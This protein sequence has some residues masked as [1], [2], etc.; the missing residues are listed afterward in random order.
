MVEEARPQPD[1]FAVTNV[2][3]DQVALFV[4]EKSIDKTV[5][6]ALQKIVAQKTVV[7]DLESKKSDLDDEQSQIFRRPAAAP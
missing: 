5:E 2:T 4:R 1:T 6:D 7:A 3:S